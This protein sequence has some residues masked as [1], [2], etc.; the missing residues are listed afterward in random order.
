[1][2]DSQTAK[3]K[4]PSPSVQRNCR[5]KVAQ[6][7]EKGV[8][9]RPSRCSKCGRKC[10]PQAHHDDYKKP[11]KVTWLCGSCH[12]RRHVKRSSHG[13]LSRYNNDR[14]RCRKCRDANA[15]YQR[16]YRNR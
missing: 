8:L 1:V 15:E 7:I 4:T 13:T 14:C 2:T 5:V 10:K 11:L 3:I 16:R 6:A 9:E 12:K